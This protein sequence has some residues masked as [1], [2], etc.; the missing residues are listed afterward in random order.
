MFYTNQGV[1]L[2][3]CG[4]TLACVTVDRPGDVAGLCLGPE[5]HRSLDFTGE[6]K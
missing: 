6:T 1:S 2:V 4:P 3:L 5:A